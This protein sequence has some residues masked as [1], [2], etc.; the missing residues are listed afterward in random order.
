MRSRTLV[1]NSTDPRNAGRAAD[2]RY[3]SMSARDLGGHTAPID[4][5][6]LSSPERG[7]VTAAIG[8]GGN[9]IGMGNVSA[10]VKR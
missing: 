9:E 1:A 3:Y 7:I 8:D 2:G 6:F 4:G 10:L 5:W